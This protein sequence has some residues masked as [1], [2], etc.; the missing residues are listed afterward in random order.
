[1]VAT[2]YFLASTAIH[3][4]KNQYTDVSLSLEAD[5]PWENFI[6]P[7]PTVISLLGQLMVLSGKVD[8]SLA[9]NS[10]NRTF[11]YIRNPTSFRATL[12]QVSNDGWSAFINAH[13]NMDKIQL[14]M[15]QIPDH[16]KTA[17]KILLQASPQLIKR[18]LPDTL[19]QI[20]D[21][22]NVCV[23]LSAETETKFNN[24]MLLLG[25]ILEATEVSRGGYDAKLLAAQVELNTSVVQKQHL[26]NIGEELRKRQADID[27][28]VKKYQA[29]Y[30]KA[31]REIPTGWKAIA[32]DFVRAGA[33][34]LNFFT[35]G[36]GSGSGGGG[37]NK[38]G[39]GGN[40][41]FQTSNVMS[42][43]QQYSEQL[44]K[45]KDGIQ[46]AFSGQVGPSNNPGE[47][48]QSYSIGLNIWKS[49]LNSAGTAGQVALQLVN[50]GEGICN[51]MKNLFRNVLDVNI[52]EEDKSSIMQDTDELIAKVKPMGAAGAYLSNGMSMQ[53][54][55]SPTIGSSS[56]SGK[57]GNERFKV[58][59]TAN[60][61]DH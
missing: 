15:T 54:G 35:G 2:L 38:S 33:N 27:N 20:K 37:A 6:M 58:L 48:F 10:P 8:F 28:E 32:M 11:Q 52:S 36:G 30:E 3:S 46:Q 45:I 21:I 5:T 23:Q 25:E 61:K 39:P 4:L 16:V 43:M 29:A 13:K 26:E 57:Y 50:N 42:I 53:N 7:G 22:G 9:E 14:Y 24:V 18:L 17:L 44:F 55:G 12:V 31:L 1:M 59:Y 41:D 19:S 51:R 47:M 56:F 60:Y 40:T 34:L 49:M